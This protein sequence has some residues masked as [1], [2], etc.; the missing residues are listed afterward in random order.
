MLLVLQRRR[1]FHL[2]SRSLG[3]VQKPRKGG[4]KS[5][6][7]NEGLFIMQFPAVGQTSMIVGDNPIGQ[8]D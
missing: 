8:G 7:E 4:K 5:K 1:D 3:P 2:P 6:K